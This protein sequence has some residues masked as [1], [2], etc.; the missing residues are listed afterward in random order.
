MRKAVGVVIIENGSLLLVQKRQVWILP[1]GKPE[2]G[3]TDR[4]CLL[5]EVQEEELPG[6]V[7]HDLKYFGTFVGTTPHQGDQLQAEVYLADAGGDIT[8]SAEVSKAEWV[9]SSDL[10]K[11][12]LSGISRQII[13]S[14]RQNGYL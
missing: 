10:G 12:N 4:Q 3:E 7:L 14:L 8:P 9:K 5:R 1:G 11:Y 6:L 2:E 13:H